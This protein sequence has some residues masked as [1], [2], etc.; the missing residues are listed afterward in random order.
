[1]L[2]ERTELRNIAII[3][4]ADRGKAILVESRPPPRWSGREATEL[5]ASVGLVSADDIEDQDHQAIVLDR[6][7]DP[8]VAHSDAVKVFELLADQL[9]APAW[10]GFGG[11]I[12]DRLIQTP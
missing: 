12:S 8:P 5:S 7:E 6:V 3:A 10:S 11:E 4:H 9:L 2:T 1:M